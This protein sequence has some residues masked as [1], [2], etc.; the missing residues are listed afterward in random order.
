MSEN[1]KLNWQEFVGLLSEK[2]E[3]PESEVAGFAQELFALIAETISEDE[4]V[5][6]KD[7]GTFK[8]IPVQA[9][10]SVDVNT[11]EK[12]EIPAHYRLN[13]LPS[14]ALRELVNKPFSHFETTLLN[15]G[16]NLEDI[17]IEEGEGD[18]DVD[19]SEESDPVIIE[20]R[21][22]KPVLR[23]SEDGPSTPETIPEIPVSEDPPERIS[24][25]RNLQTTSR[26][27]KRSHVLAL[28]TLGGIVVAIT[29]AAFFFQSRNDG[30]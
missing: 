11:G 3:I 15:Q 21:M 27:N 26:R 12:I 30:K 6:I 28:M 24:V 14:T 16:V 1:Y 25:T 13:F 8:L 10:E 18:T 7:F 19:F 23:V 9:R 22:E 17:L 29:A 4:W 20:K 2:A 5:K